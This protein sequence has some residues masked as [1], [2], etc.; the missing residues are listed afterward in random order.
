MLPSCLIERNKISR[1]VLI[2]Y[3]YLVGYKVETGKLLVDSTR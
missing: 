2:K 1:F 3:L